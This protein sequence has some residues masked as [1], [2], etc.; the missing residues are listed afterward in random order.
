MEIKTLSDNGIKFIAKEEGCILHPYKDEAGI[1]TIGIGCT[2]YANGIRVKPTD[3]ILTISE[4]YALFRIISK[5]FEDTVWSVT[6]DDITQNMFDALV[7][8]SY[9]IGIGHFKSSTVLKMVNLNPHNYG[10]REAFLMWD[11]R[12][13]PRTGQLVV[14]AGLEARRKREAFLYLSK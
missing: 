3:E 12:M 1:W 4:A 7:S 5:V 2:Y 11:K 14:S 6:R 10:I 8:L 9:N 13:D